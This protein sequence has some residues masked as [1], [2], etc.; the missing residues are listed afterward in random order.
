MAEFFG[1]TGSPYFRQTAIL[2]DLIV[3]SSP[4][5]RE[6]MREMISRYAFT[7][8]MTGL[9]FGCNFLGCSLRRIVHHGHLLVVDMSNDLIPEREESILVGFFVLVNMDRRDFKGV[10]PV[11]VN[12][13]VGNS[14]VV[15]LDVN[16]Q[17]VEMQ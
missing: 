1:T 11:G 9:M 16:H 5:G 7:S 6:R 17:H 2:A 8:S 13:F 15:F 12:F 14:F 10:I 3:D 4:G